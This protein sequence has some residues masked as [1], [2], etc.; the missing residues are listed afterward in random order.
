MSQNPVLSACYSFLVPVA[1]FLLR[2]GVSFKDFTELARTAFIQVAGEEYGIRG[3]ATNVSRVSAMTGIPRKEV[4]RIRDIVS[5]Y[6]SNPREEISLLGDILHHWYTDENFLDSDGRPLPLPAYGKGATFELLAKHCAGDL[7]SGALKIE[8]LRTGAVTLTEDGQLVPKRRQAVPER[9]DDKLITSLS[10]NLYGLASTIAYNSDPRRT[11][12]GRI[13]RFVQSEHIPSESKAIVR[14]SLRDR[15][16]R[17]TIDLDN[18]FSRTR[19][20]STQDISRVGVGVYY[21]EEEN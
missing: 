8:L 12:A 14:D 4:R 20:I 21:F 19:E 1:R 5:R 7:P 18:Y 15:I 3:R 2:N 16:D 11:G 6:G 9:L 17:F 13:E 10:F